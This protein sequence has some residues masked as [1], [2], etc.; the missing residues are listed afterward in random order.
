ML[1]NKYYVDVGVDVIYNLNFDEF[2]DFTG[3]DYCKGANHII[4]QRVDA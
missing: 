1:N 4:E 2:Y 3:R